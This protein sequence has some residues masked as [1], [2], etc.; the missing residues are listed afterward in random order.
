MKGHH[1]YLSTII[2]LMSLF[3][4]NPARSELFI[5]QV[6]V[7]FIYIVRLPPMYLSCQL[8][9]LPYQDNKRG[10]K[11]LFLFL[12]SQYFMSSIILFSLVST[13]QV[14]TRLRSAII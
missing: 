10:S 5:Y 6:N 2:T 4:A 9:D 11:A 3:I 7:I 1:L 14:S 8:R 12:I 13:Y